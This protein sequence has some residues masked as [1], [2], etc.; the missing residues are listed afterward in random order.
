[1]TRH[2]RIATR[3]ATNLSLDVDL[4]ADAKELGINLSRACEEAL[5]SEIAAERGRRWKEDNAAGIAAS[6]AYVEKHGLPL[7]KYRQF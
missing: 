3:K 5:R 7:E 1:M 6:N 2:K 4:V